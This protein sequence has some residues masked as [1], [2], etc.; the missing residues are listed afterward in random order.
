[1]GQWLAEASPGVLAAIVA[2]VSVVA[3][4]VTYL[5]YVR[6][7]GPRLS[8]SLRASRTGADL[9]D[10]LHPMLVHCL[11][12]GERLHGILLAAQ[13]RPFRFT[14]T[15]AVGVTD[16][17]LLL[18]PLDLAGAAD[19]APISLTPHEVRSARLREDGGP[20]AA[21]VLGKGLS[22]TLRLRTLD[23]RK[24]VVSIARGG[25][26]WLGGSGQAGGLAALE[27]WVARCSSGAARP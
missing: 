7:G 3:V 15:Y 23:G 19:G 2:G 1:M 10:V 22:V 12:P 13:L 16:D 27:R 14:R 4:V 25:S 8:E 17:R 9:S 24:I 21:G 6:R 5:L 18:Q 26:R 20:A 11:H